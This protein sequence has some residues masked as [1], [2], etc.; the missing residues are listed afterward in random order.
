MDS[1][2]RRLKDLAVDAVPSEEVV[3]RMRASLTDH[4]A[5]S[6]MRDHIQ[7]IVDFAEPT[8]LASTRMRRRMNDH[9]APRSKTGHWRRGVAA[10]LAAAALATVLI[11]IPLGSRDPGAV[12]LLNIAEAVM[13]IPDTEF[14]DATIER[15]SDR[16]VLTVEPIEAA[17]GSRS[18]V[19]FHLPIEEA[20]RI[21]ADSVVQVD[22][23]AGEL[24]F[25][26]PVDQDTAAALSDLYSIGVTETLTVP[27]PDPSTGPSHLT[28]DPELVSEQIHRRIDRFGPPEVPVEIQ[29]M[30]EVATIYKDELPANREKAALLTVMAQTDGVTLEAGD[31]TGTVSVSGRYSYDD[32]T[33]V[34]LTLVFS[35]D[36]W[37]QRETET[38]LDGIHR[39]GVPAGTAAFDTSY[40]PPVVA[41]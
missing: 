32:G 6:Q 8:E 23:T 5:N 7:A 25:F 10:A 20:W 27:A 29:V 26:T 17:D 36:G 3:G 38:L 28:D 2:L 40:Q 19:A 21:D 22:Q 24:R 18:E 14:G 15:R 9:V 35:P 30:W 39:L 12:A 11:V 13:A 41:Q 1:D 34:E 31:S 37:L 33:R 4:I 16:L